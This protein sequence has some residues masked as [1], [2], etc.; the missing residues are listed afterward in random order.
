MVKHNKATPEF[1]SADFTVVARKGSDVMVESETGKTYRR[2]V[3]H[4]KRV[5]SPGPKEQ[6]QSPQAEYMQGNVLSRPKRKITKPR[7]F[8]G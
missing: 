5:A 8:E 2:N 6:G 4:L 7:R 1:G 3:T